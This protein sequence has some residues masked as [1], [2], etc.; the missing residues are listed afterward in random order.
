VREGRLDASF[1]FGELDQAEFAGLPL[2]ETA[3]RIAAP[4][5]WRARVERAGWQEIAALPWILTPPISTHSRLVQAMFA[6]HG[7][8]PTKVM[9]ADNESVIANLVESGLGLS[10]LRE[11]LAREAQAA[12]QVCLWSDARLRTTLWFVALEKQ[13]TDPAIAAL[14]GVLQQLWGLGD[15]ADDASAARLPE[16]AAL[17]P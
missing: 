8:S 3:Y 7:V 10:L 14:R 6:E 15:S 1:Y 4:A 17:E 2:T 12:G 5:A 16:R 13:V 9:Q 11:A